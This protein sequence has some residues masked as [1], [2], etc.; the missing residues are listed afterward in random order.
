MTEAGWTRERPSKEGW[1][2]FRNNENCESVVQVY[3]HVDEGWFLSGPEIEHCTF[4][5]IEHDEDDEPTDC[6]WLGPITPDS[7][8]QGRVEGARDE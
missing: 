4:D 6:E 8:Q 1:Y 7:Y 3:Q 5:E 2:W